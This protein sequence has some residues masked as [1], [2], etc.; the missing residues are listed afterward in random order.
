V[1]FRYKDY[2]DGGRVKVTRLEAVEFLRRFL[3]HVLPLGFQRLRSYGLLANRHR[4]ANL[5]KCRQLLGCAA[6]SLDASGGHEG[7]A[8]E[9]DRLTGEDPRRCPVCGKGRRVLLEAVRSHDERHMQA[10]RA[11]PR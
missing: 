3:R 2:R 8:E 1:V 5:E 11:P 9:V 10:A 6:P 4:V 7:W